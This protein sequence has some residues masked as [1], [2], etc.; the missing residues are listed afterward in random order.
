M[1]YLQAS[2]AN[3]TIY[4]TLAG[5][6]ATT[7]LYTDV[8]VSYL[9]AGASVVIPLTLTADQWLNLGNG[10][11]SIQ[12]PPTATVVV[13]DFT[14]FLSSDL[15]DNFIFGELTIEPV[16]A[17]QEVVLPQQ[18]IVT[19]TVL[20]MSALGPNR[21]Q[22]R[23]RGVGFPAKTG[24]F[25]LS[26]DEVWTWVDAYGNFSLPLI[27]NAIMMVEIERAGVRAQITVPDAP[28]ASLISLLPPI[29]FDYSIS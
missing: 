15:F 19:G 13:G 24:A 29:D 8:S 5:I 7:I 27:R 1:A 11:Y 14:F 22:V 20:N 12:F 21:L 16:P 2:P 25:L 3:K 18:C 26:G 28:T 6:P 9:P 4:L 23:A 17:T 10:V